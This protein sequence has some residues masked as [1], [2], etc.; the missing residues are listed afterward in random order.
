V[1]LQCD[2]VNGQTCC[3]GRQHGEKADKSFVLRQLGEKSQKSNKNQRKDF[4][5]KTL[6]KAADRK[7]RKK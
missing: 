2:V 6:F 1:G 3:D 5:T 7:Y 4:T